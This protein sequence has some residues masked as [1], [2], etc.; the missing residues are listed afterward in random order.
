MKGRR[1]PVTYDDNGIP[2]IPYDEMHPGDYCGPVVGFT[3][4]L[5]AVFFLKPNARDPDAPLADRAVQH[6]CSPP[7][8]FTEMP[9]GSLQ[10]R[11][12]ISDKKRVQTSGEGDGWHGYLDAGHEWRRV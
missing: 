5:P 7:H 11:E 3:G 1:L 10:I 9:D 8:V 12:S 6:V 4:D 2:Q